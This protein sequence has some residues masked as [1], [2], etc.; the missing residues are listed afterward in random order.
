MIL[1]FLILAVESSVPRVQ[2]S[3]RACRRTHS[4]RPCETQTLYPHTRDT[5]HPAGFADT[6][7]TH[8]HRH[9]HIE[10]SERL[11]SA[12][13]RPTRDSTRPARRDQHA[14]R[15][16]QRGHGHAQMRWMAGTHAHPHGAPSR[17]ST[18]RAICGKQC[19]RNT[20]TLPPAHKLGAPSAEHDRPPRGHTP[21]GRRAALVRGSRA[22]AASPR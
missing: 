5:A 8:I 13:P 20:T 14:S 17:P 22:P 10:I 11:P 21:R 1:S 9:T 2:E 18:A 4:S 12:P 3:T 7:G 15:H 16:H 6:P 19:V